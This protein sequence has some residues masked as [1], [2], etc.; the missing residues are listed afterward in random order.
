MSWDYGFRPYVPVGERRANARRDLAKKLGKG[1][2]AS[3]VFIEGR[4]IAK[5]FWGESWCQQ[6]EEHSDFASRLPRGRTY[7]R[8][9]SVV[10]LAIDKGRIEAIVAGSDTYEITIK[11]KPLDAKIWS[12]LVK[13][14]A[15]QVSSIVD[16][17]QGKLPRTVL[18]AIAD[19]A[20]KLF[21][22]PR[23][24]EFDCTCPDWADMCKHVAAVLYGVGARLDADPALFF[25]LRA[26]DMNELV[27]VE[28]ATSLTQTTDDGGLGDADLSSLFG[29]E[30]EPAPVVARPR[31]RSQPPVKTSKAKKKPTRAAKLRRKN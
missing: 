21:P 20:T 22:Q 2:K 27:A 8:N 11:V 3:P 24:L 26:A 18:E 19:P 17:L 29:I 25:T 28:A 1:V 23:E 15:G 7:V 5:S 4:K 9:G 10:H 16:V 13:K 12:G 31:G 6:M 30:L 14:C